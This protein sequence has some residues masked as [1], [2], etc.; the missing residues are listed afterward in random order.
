MTLE[1]VRL[2]RV[3]G[4]PIP[5]LEEVLLALPA[6]MTIYVELRGERVERVAIDAMQRAGRP[7]PIHSFDHEMIARAGRIAPDLPRGILFD[8]GA[9]V[10]TA[11]IRAAAAAAGA[12]DLWPHYSLVSPRFVDVARSLDAHVITWTVN[13]ATRAQQL[14]ELGVY[15]LCGDDVR[16]LAT[17]PGQP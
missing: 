14:A 12:R 16:L 1:Q 5:T 17:S 3:D 6:A 15:G 7:C 8:Q 11:F 10:D 9:T 13:D 4:Q 2:L